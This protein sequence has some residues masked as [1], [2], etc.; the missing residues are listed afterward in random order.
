MNYGDFPVGAK[1]GDKE[2]KECPHCRKNGLETKVNGETYYNHGDSE[3]PLTYQDFYV[4]VTFCPKS[5][6]S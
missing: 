3:L 4:G 5:K 1:F 6:Q 2:I